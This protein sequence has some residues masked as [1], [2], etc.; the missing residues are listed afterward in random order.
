MPRSY[1]FIPANKPKLFDR[2]DSLDADAYIFDL[3]DAVPGEAKAE[4]LAQLSDWLSGRGSLKGLYLRVNGFEHPVAGQERD[5]LD[6]FPTLGVVLPKVESVVGLSRSIDFYGLG[7]KRRLIGLIESP[8]GLKNLDSILEVEA[9]CAIGLG[10]EDFLSDSIFNADQLDTLVAT[11][12][13]QIALAAMSWEI[14]AIDTISL[15][16][17]AGA[18]LDDDVL[19]ARSAGFSA[20]FSIHP[21]QIAVINTYF[22]PA[23]GFIAKAKLLEQELEYLSEESG[24][25]RTTDSTLLS[26]PTL[27]K[28]KRVLQ[29][30]HHDER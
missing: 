21:S 7:G 15:N 4:S 24:Y 30:M 3:E 19:V 20:K 2:V 29:Y 16:F 23:D 6:Q 8:F 13:A 25:F 18:A 22:S 11:V 27:K 1:H 5:F 12:R 17:I 26:P 28:L 9:L 10:L 14:E